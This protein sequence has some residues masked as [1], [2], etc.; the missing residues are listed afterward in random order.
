MLLI[1]DRNLTSRTY[2]RATADAIAA[3]IGDSYFGCF[4]ELQTIL[5]Q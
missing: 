5:Q 2:N 3:H 1:Q 4:H